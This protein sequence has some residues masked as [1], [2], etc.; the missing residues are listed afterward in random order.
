MTEAT[1][2]LVSGSAG[3][4]GP[5]PVRNVLSNWAGF[6]A[7]ALIS[8]VLAPFVV[9]TLGDSQYG[10]WVLLASV[11]GYLGLL[12]LGVRGAVT[13][14]VASLHAAEKHPEAGL[15]A[16]TALSIFLA[17]GAVAVGVS[18]VLAAIAP[19]LFDIPEELIGVARVVFVLGGLSIAASL[20]AGVFGGV[21]VGL[22]RFDLVNAAG[23]VLGI[24]RAGLIVLML[25]LGGGL[26]ALAAIQLAVSAAQGLA[27]YVLSRRTYPALR[28]AL[29]A[30]SRAH[31]REIMSFGVYSS[32]LQASAALMLYTDSVV[33]GAFLPVSAITFFSIGATLTDYVRQ[34]VSGIST[35]LMPMISSLQ[36]RTGKTEAERVLLDASRLANLIVLPIIVTFLLRGSAFIGLWMGPSYV[37]QSDRVLWILAVTLSPF[38]TY[39]VLTSAVFGLNEHRKLA[40]F[41]LIEAVTNVGLSVILVR[42]FGIL[43][44][45]WGTALPRL[46]SCLTVGPWYAHRLFGVRIR[47]YVTQTWLLPWIGMI[48]FALG[49]FTVERLWPAGN[50]AIYFAQIALTLPLA[51]VGV[52]LVALTREE[53][54]LAV[55]WLTSP[56]SAAG[57]SR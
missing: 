44:V 35:T 8:L 2:S 41:F 49:S 9:H 30:W 26:V 28:I 40:P 32:L 27:N 34:V 4:G 45:A 47:T 21:V 11:V 36:A 25:K 31:A 56:A 50:L 15:I 7:N 48:P 53:R 22:Q 29:F 24:A 51:G 54:R 19:L 6:A 33:I 38:A 52:W 43:G 57:Q 16:S 18:C 17:A 10:I 5:R 20:V 13:R 55:S 12:D 39:Q 1:P 37:G 42:E 23:V 3:R 14:Y 46:V